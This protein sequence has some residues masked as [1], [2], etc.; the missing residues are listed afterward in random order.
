ML[1]EK[2]RA[3]YESLV[4]PAEERIAKAERV[5]IVPDGFLFEV[6][7]E[8][9]VAED[10]PDDADWR[11]LAYL[12][13]RFDTV[14][15]PSAAAFLWI[16]R[17]GERHDYDKQLIAFG[18]PDL[19]RFSRGPAVGLPTLPHSRLEVERIAAQIRG[20]EKKIFL[21][22]EATETRFKELARGEE[23]PRIVH[24]ATHGVVDRAEP[25]AS[26]IV[27]APDSAAG[28]DGYLHTLEIFSLP[29][30]VG[31]AVLSACE[32]ARGRIGRGEGVVGLGR[33]FLASGASGLVASLW[34]VSDESTAALMGAFYERM[35]G[36]KR[37]AARALREARITLLEDG[38]HAHPFYWSAFVVVGTL[39]APW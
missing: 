33:A 29:M 23:A 20:P 31:L 19:A 37:P 11:N 4:E 1:R 2:S 32:S 34:E 5:V 13:R 39:D 16:S 3:L 12:G 28:D 38:T 24:L 8:A 7:F 18:D 21:G 10:I 15:A 14:Y 9:L 6:P 27:L 22:G 17:A 36:D 26:C 35:I 30:N 25:S